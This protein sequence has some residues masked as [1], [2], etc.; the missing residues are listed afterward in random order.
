MFDFIKR[1]K[2]QKFFTYETNTINVKGLQSGLKDFNFGIGEISISPEF[3]KAKDELQR[4]DLIQFSIC[5]DIQN[6]PK[7]SS[8]RDELLKKSVDVKLKMLELVSDIQS[9]SDS[10]K[11]KTI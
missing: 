9:K 8:L 5:N 10:E 4:L 11:K 1:K 7:N 2:C 3:V 6:L